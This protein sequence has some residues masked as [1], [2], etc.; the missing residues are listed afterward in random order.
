MAQINL[1]RVR[2]LFRGEWSASQAYDFFDWVTSSGSSYVCIKSGC[3]AG[4]GV[5]NTTYWAELAQRGDDGSTGVAA[6]FGTPT[7][8]ATA[9]AAGSSPTVAVT[10]S[11]T[12]T[13]KVF[14]FTFGIPKGEK[15]DTGD[16]GPTG[17]TGANGADG[18]DAVFTIMTTEPA[19]S[20][21]TEGQVVFVV[22]A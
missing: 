14:K 8:T 11:G 12:N 3:P 7:A 16:T 6:G 21:V 22:E 1:G 15:G 17:L 10:A 2:F 13:A 19:V 9:L 20:Q 5:S 4:T 18:T